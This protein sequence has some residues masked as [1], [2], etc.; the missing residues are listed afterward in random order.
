MK[1]KIIIGLSLFTLSFFLATVYVIINI[2]TTTSR[3]D[4]LVKLHQIEILREHLLIHIARVQTDLKSRERD[5]KAILT[6]VNSMAEVA[7]ACF[8]CHHVENVKKK[9]VDLK[10]HTREYKKAV[11][12]VLYADG[13]SSMKVD[14]AFRIGE[15]LITEVNSMIT[16]TSTRLDEKTN[17]ALQKI[18]DT[19]S[20]LYIVLALGPVFAAILS[21]IFIR[22]VT[23]PLHTILDATRR[24]KSGDLDYRVESLKDEFGEVAA[25]FN[26]MAG[27]LK[28]QIQNMQRTEQLKVCGEIAT[29]LAH[30]IKNP[31]AGIK[32]SMEVLSE[33]SSLSKEDRK[34]LL[35]VVGEVRRIEALL[36]GL[37]NFAK[38]PVPQFTPSNI[39]NI[40]EICMAFSIKLPSVSFGGGPKAVAVV[41]NF[42][43]G[44]PIIMADQMQ[45]QQVFLNLLLNA[46]DAMPGGGTLTIGTSRRLEGKAIGIE[47][48]DTGKGIGREALNKIFQPF[49][50]TKSKGT[51]MGLAI[52]RR[53]IEE[54][55]GVISVE[56]EKGKGTVF[57]I[58]LPVRKESEE[59]R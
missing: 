42:D 23:A 5:N 7:D 13:A 48:A 55:G 53:I 36:K 35:Q 40:I 27:S 49:F 18:A 2:E 11:S 9:L 29:G 39:N 26:E 59:Q 51:G 4:N 17:V 14:N 20:T 10:D 34:V 30:E 33:D 24:L 57:R 56:S 46:V 58:V 50:T 6:T 54:H 38:P 52:T 8:N 41:K 31:L 25:S 1:K 12:G 19:K 32:V 28:E 16:M 47:I 3:L 44:I 22:A 15:D 21:M 43:E 45:L 37:L